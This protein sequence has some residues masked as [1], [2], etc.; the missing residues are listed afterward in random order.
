MALFAC[1]RLSE[2][3]Y[4]ATGQNLSGKFARSPRGHQRRAYL[5]SSDP[6]RAVYPLMGFRCWSGFRLTPTLGCETRST[7]TSASFP[8]KFAGTDQFTWPLAETVRP[9]GPAL[10]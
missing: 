9:K 1:S 3:K 8:W 4:A 5:H 6:L 7:N 10:S 2:G